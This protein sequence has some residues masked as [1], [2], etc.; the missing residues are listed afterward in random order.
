MKILHVIP[1]LSPVYGGPTTNLLPLCEAQSALGH[2]VEIAATTANGSQNPLSR[3]QIQTNLTCHLFP[4]SFSEAWKFSKSFQNWAIVNIKKYDL[5]STHAIWSYLPYFA[6]KV[7]IHNSIPVVVRPAGML[8]P[9][10][11]SRNPLLK[12]AF[13]VLF[14]G[15]VVRKCSGFHATSQSEKDEI[16]NL[17]SN[18][19]V[20]VVP[21]ALKEDAFS[22]KSQPGFLKE[23]LG[24]RDD[25]P[26]VLFLSRLHPKKGIVDLLLP[27]FL[28]VKTD[29][30]LV[31]VGEAD[32]HEPLYPKQIQAWV[33]AAGLEKRVHYF[34]P[35]SP[36][37]RWFAYD[38]AS[39]F[40]LPSQSEN[41]GV[42]VIEAM[43]RGTPVIISDGVQIQD[44][45]VQNNAGWVVPRNV[46][47][48]ATAIDTALCSHVTR[49]PKYNVRWADVA[50]KL[51]SFYETLL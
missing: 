44:I 38:S 21:H 45:V 36:Q 25:L 8:S 47:Q 5:V 51:L 7:G 31:L 4:V 20:A 3:D 40:V 34:G 19:N 22:T 14:D 11:F 24:I 23:R 50:K 15:K 26:I 39:V 42:V 1:A 10:T 27:A 32:P 30:H 28:K 17:R 12:K 18:A 43:A 2:D 9:Y 16:L 35:V 29:S 41:F 46:D 37:E 6:G 13:W 49:E 48:W 33:K